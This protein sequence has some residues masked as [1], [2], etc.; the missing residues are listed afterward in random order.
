MKAA[1]FRSL[2]VLA[3][4]PTL[5]WAQRREAK[6]AVVIF[7]DG[8]YVKGKAIQ[9]KDWLIDPAT[10]AS[11]VIP[12]GGEYLYVDDD[13]RRINFSMAQ[14]QDVLEVEAERIKD[15]SR[16]WFFR[17]NLPKVA[18]KPIPSGWQ[19]EGVGPW[20]D[21]WERTVKVST[22]AGR[23]Q[24]IVQRLVTVTPRYVSGY[25]VGYHWTFS[26]Q[27]RE[28][29]V[30]EVRK[31]VLDFLVEKTKFKDLERR[32]IVTRFLAEA[33][34]YEPALNELDDI[35][36]RFP[37]AKTALKELQ[38]KIKSQQAEQWAEYVLKL[39]RA[40][41]HEMVQAEL[42]AF[43]RNPDNGA[44]LADKHRLALQD[45]KTR[46]ETS[47]ADLAQARDLLKQLPKSTQQR[48][49]TLACK[50]I[51]EELNSDTISR[52]KTFLEV[53]P[54][55]ARQLKAMQTPT[56]KTEEVLA[57]AVSGWLQGDNAASTDAKSA[58]QLWHTRQ[59][60]LDYLRNDNAGARREAVA[61]FRKY[62]DIPIDVVIRII[63]QLPPVQGAD[64]PETGLTKMS[65][66]AP[67][68]DGGSY[69]LQL[70]PEYTQTRS[71]PVLLLLHSHREGADALL[72]RWQAEAGRHGFILA[73]PIWG[74]KALQPNYGYS[75][76]EHAVVLDTLRDLRRRFNV[77]SD[78]VFLYGWEQGGTAAFD[79]GLAHPDQF[80][81][82]LPMNGDVSYYPQRY[83]TNGQFLPFY[84]LEGDRN[85]MYPKNT[86]A[87][88]KDWIRWH[89]P[90]LYVEYKGR[91]SEW[92]GTEIA[93][94]MDW[95]SRKKRIHPM[96][97]MGR[98]H[99]G[100]AVGMGEEF[101]ILRSS[102][103]RFYWLST[104]AVTDSHI[105]EVR[106]WQKST[107]PATLQA[108]CTVVNEETKAGPR[109]WT[110][111]NLRTSGVKQVS[112]WI[113]PNQIDF[114]RPVRIRH[115]G[116]LFGGDRHL[117]PNLGTLLEEL[118]TSGDRQ[119][120]FVARLDFRL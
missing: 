11:M 103:N 37:E 81:G 99:T 80:A 65:I 90:S 106:N 120:L 119:R 95:M 91:S 29:D 83:A 28:L 86:R 78:R 113:A 22:A 24:Q 36:E 5:T 49:W 33:G 45:I 21:K 48:D 35:G 26:Y 70:P 52:L 44:L 85:G 92:F 4:F 14:V 69:Y 118:Y 15:Q 112:L 41:Q 57:L 6:D 31:L 10:G 104:S 79:I 82:V 108:S 47:G 8:F 20:N 51:L 97:E 38:E 63:R 76:A 2:L 75:P 96:K 117:Q 114:S 62:N 40:G 19:F 101:K 61:T 42:G 13:V 7:K 30:K 54:Q 71:Y 115:N 84:I 73:A 3:L 27:T 107:R 32:L 66:E 67:D 58:L 18:G 102:D 17:G 110:Q 39:H 100:G 105:N 89:Y 72:K 77:D 116:T 43:D 74:G 68:S 53:A 109:I 94:M 16:L 59:F 64:K 60:L 55:H 98:Y 87:F 9:K 111:F 23:N 25:A 88:F 34:A 56:Q 93:T 50:T 46:Y 12:A 1:L